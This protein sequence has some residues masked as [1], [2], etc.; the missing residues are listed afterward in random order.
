MEL[1]IEIRTNNSDFFEFTLN[2]L[3]S[4]GWKI[5]KKSVKKHLIFRTDKCYCK[6]IKK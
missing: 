6:L 3:V 2:R 5:N 1:H 4:E